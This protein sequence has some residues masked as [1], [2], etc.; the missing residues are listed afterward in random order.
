MEKI[1][2]YGVGN[3]F[4]FSFY[5]LS[6]YYDIVA[7]SDG[8]KNKRGKKYGNYVVYDVSEINDE[9]YDYF[10]YTPA[11]VEGIREMLLSHSVKQGKIISL[12]DALDRIPITRWQE[13][14]LINCNS[15]SRIALIL[16][17]GMGDLLI[18]RVWIEKL[19]GEYELVLYDIDIYLS[20][21]NIEVGKYIYSFLGKGLTFY[22]IDRLNN[23]ANEKQYMA[24]IRYCIFP[25][26]ICADAEYLKSVNNSF[27]KYISKLYEFGLFN[28]NRGLF[29]SRNYFKTVEKLFLLKEKV[30]YHNAYNVLNNL[31]CSTADRINILYAECH[32]VL[33]KYGLEQRNFI[34]INTGLNAEYANKLNTREWPSR[35]W[36]EL[37]CQI[38]KI[39]PDLLIVQVGTKVRGENDI[40]ADIHLNGKTNLKEIAVIL[41][42]ALFHLDYD[43]GLVHVNHMVG[44]K[45][46]VLMG[47]SLA[48]KH[49]YP[50]N[51]YI[52]SPSCEGCEWT[53]PDW[54]SKCPKGYGEPICMNGIT[55]N[56]VMNVIKKV[57]EKD[58]NE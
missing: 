38:R 25:E 34:T 56:M 15:N 12:Q 31:N 30:L 32:K 17:G 23:T 13:G 22:S 45:S 50:E 58:G 6:Q 11:N 44:G 33:E 19:I 10:V 27:S 46:I 5:E 1:A 55:V 24:I 53:A 37:S 28:Y 49:Q 2:I 29:T 51:E 57:V 35:K 26:V 3:N 18:S 41:G 52:Q 4:I 54:L 7:I 8:D 16:Y 20:E 42:K 21:K 48:I 40:S 39:Y 9:K 43:G 47:P 36:E 14:K